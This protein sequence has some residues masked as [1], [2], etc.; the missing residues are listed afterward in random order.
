MQVFRT[1]AIFPRL[2]EKFGGE[3]F[4]PVGES[5]VAILISVPDAFISCIVQSDGY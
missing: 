4:G 5:N 2:F 1:V 3:E